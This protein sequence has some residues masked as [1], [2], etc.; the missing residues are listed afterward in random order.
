MYVCMYLYTTLTTY[1]C[2][3]LDSFLN[4]SEN[5]AEIKRLLILQGVLVD[6][7]SM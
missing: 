1:T 3:S 7:C 5:F 2:T 6:L 4:I